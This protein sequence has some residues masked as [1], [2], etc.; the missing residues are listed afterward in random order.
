MDLKN[1]MKK[2]F[3]M[4]KVD[5]ESGLERKYRGRME[6]EMRIEIFWKNFLDI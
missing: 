1:E 4:K 5:M 6:M 3:E 2:K